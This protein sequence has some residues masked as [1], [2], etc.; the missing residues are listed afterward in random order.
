MLYTVE[1]VA[2][3]LNVSKATIYNKLKLD[4]FKDKIIMEKGQ[5]MLNQNLIDLIKLETKFKTNAETKTG[6]SEE[7]LVKLNLK[8]V[9]SLME[10][11]KEARAKIKEKDIIIAEQLFESNLRVKEANELT[12]NG[13]ELQSQN[14]KY[15]ELTEKIREAEPPKKSFIG[16]LFKK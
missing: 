16:K 5:T 9:D 10:E 11:L 8:L 3:Q 7:D 13:Q 1:Q 6:I 15:I 12:R 2:D 4:H 14:I